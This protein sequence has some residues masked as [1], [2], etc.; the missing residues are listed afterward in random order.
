MTYTE[1][2]KAIKTALKAAGITSKQ[3]SVSHR[4]AGY[5]DAWRIKIRDGNVSQLEVKTICKPF[6]VID[7]EERTGEILMGGN[8]YITVE[9]EF[10]V[11]ADGSEYLDAVKTALS[12]LERDGQGERIEG[13]RWIIFKDGNRYFGASLEIQK[14]DWDLSRFFSWDCEG[15]AANIANIIKSREL[16]A[17][18]LASK[19]A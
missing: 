9:F 15:V 16:D 8:D 2:T 5:S 7:I 13:T 12:K 18:Y 3:V 6:Q 17:A 19:G 11:C 10:G 1:K 14:I 4:S